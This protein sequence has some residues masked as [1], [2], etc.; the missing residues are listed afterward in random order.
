ML[1]GF[2][3]VSA[4]TRVATALLTVRPDSPRVVT[5]IALAEWMDWD[6]EDD[7]LLTSPLAPDQA[8]SVRREAR[9]VPVRA[10][11]SFVPEMLNL[12]EDVGL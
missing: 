2:G 8:R 10:R 7:K 4:Y 5:C 12:I 11:C 9:R 6:F 1:V 3:I